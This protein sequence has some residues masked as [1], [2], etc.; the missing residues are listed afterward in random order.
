MQCERQ[1]EQS[2]GID[3]CAGSLLL[4]RL[5]GA[6]HGRDPFIAAAV[7]GYNPFPTIFYRQ[8]SSHAAILGKAYTIP[9]K[10]VSS[11]PQ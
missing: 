1:D 9:N 11:E 5:G 10:I 2:G 7:S 4:P 3:S 8:G 6:G